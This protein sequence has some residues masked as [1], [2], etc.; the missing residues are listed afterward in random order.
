MLLVVKALLTAAAACAVLAAPTSAAAPAKSWALPQ[1]EVVT[2]RGAFTATP[3][4]F[5]P[6]DPVTAGT[7]ARVVASVRDEPAAPAAVPAASVTLA[8]LD[9]TLVRALGLGDAARGFYLSARR[10]GLKPPSRFGTEVVAR[11]IGLRVNHPAAQDALE[12]QP[13][14]PATRAEAAYSIAQMLAFTGREVGAARAA[15]AALT[16]PMLTPLQQRVLQVAISFIGYPYVWGGEDERTERGFDCSGFV[17]RV[18]RTAKYAEAPQL[19]LTLRG[20]T[21]VELSGEVPQRRRVAFDDLA[22]GDVLFFGKGL[23]SKPIDVSHAGI[24]LGG[25]WMIHSS[26]FGVA[27]A[28]VDGWYR[29][30]FA[31]ARRPLAEAGLE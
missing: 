20:R 18:Y 23:A 28:A 7:L 14:E 8:Q 22:P 29:T 13:Q 12:L 24:Y 17:W 26:R 19:A 9:A 4:T 31:W 5:R 2:E 15:A 11:L 3:D 16:L 6:D 25:G 10:T 27:L 30:S 21:T 1:I